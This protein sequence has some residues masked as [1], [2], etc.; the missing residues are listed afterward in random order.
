[1]KIYQLIILA[2]L[3]IFLISCKQ[4]PEPP[5]K[6]PKPERTLK[7][8]CI[9]DQIMLSEKLDSADRYPAQLQWL[10]GNDY[11]VKTFALKKATVLKNGNQPFIEDTL[12]KQAISFQPDIVVIN[13]GINDTKMSNWWKYGEEFIDDYMKI[14]KTFQT[15]SSKPKVLICRPTKP[16]N[17]VNGIDDSTMNVGVLPNID[18]VATWLDVEKIDLY[19]ISSYRRDLFK[20]YLYP[21]KTA[22]RMIAETIADAITSDIEPLQ[23]TTTK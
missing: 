23:G 10:L 20:Q 14:V 21:D 9:G 17:I 15:I 8:A 4:T 11:L 13:L 1:M 3:S 18:S 16:F 7:I 6:K 12:F 5:K 22:C 2:C 19:T